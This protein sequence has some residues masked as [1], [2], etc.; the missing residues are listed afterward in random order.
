LGNKDLKPEFSTEH[1]AGLDIS[2]LDYRSVLSLTYARTTTENQ[3]LQVPVANFTGFRTQ[4][5]NAGTLQSKTWEATLDLRLIETS[6]FSW[7]TKLLFDATQSKITD[8][9]APD[10]RY[11][12]NVFLARKGEEIGTFYGFQAA[13]GCEH[14]P[15]GM[16]CDEF[17][18]NDDGFLVWVGP[19]G[20]LD[21]PQWGTGG[22]A[23]AGIPVK[24]GT[25]FAGYCVDRVTKE[26]TQYCPVGKSLPDYNLGLSTTLTW[27]PLTAYALLSRSAGFYLGSDYYHW[28]VP[29]MYDQL[30]VP[31][32][33]RK[34]VGY[35]D[36][37]FTLA[38]GGGV[39]S[40]NMH[41]GT[42]T[43][44][45]EL[46]LVYQIGPDL[47][48]RVPGLRGF[49]AVRLRLTGQNLFTWTD[50]PG[51]DPDVG[52][53]DGQVASAAISR[54]DSNDYPHMRTFTGGIEVVF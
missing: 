7:S 3:I 52:W 44:L 29:G 26:K 42:F 5:R 45:R 30:Q 41:D 6:A 28:G 8:L 17:A 13:M 35:Y 15:D 10:F 19:A 16:P 14:L 27:G 37:W 22:P 1:E 39:R 54:W 20:S 24:W 2:L 21:N 31:E 38:Q 53:Q 43:K 46:S 12:Y 11:E 9:N 40:T 49:E 51:Y 25:P 48:S 23:I 32:G 36:A 33:Q 4:W 47:L 50:Y 18:V 34:P